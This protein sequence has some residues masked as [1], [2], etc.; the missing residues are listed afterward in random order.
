MSIYVLIVYTGTVTD[1]EFCSL[2]TRGETR[3]LHV[4]QLIHDAR[5]Q[6]RSMSKKKLEGCLLVQSGIKGHST[7]MYDS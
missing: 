6:A 5:E 2:R 7:I 1:G 3:S 4:W